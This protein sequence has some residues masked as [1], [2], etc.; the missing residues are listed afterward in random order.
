MS[1]FVLIHG[2][3]DVGWSWH[4]VAAELEA[5][6]HE[7]F[8]PDL[9]ADDDSLTLEDYTDAVVAAVGARQDTVVVG[10]SFGAFTAPLVAER[11][12][13]RLLVLAAGMI[14]LPGEPPERWWADSGYLAAAEEQAAR[15]GGLTGND[16]PYVSFYQDVPRWLVDEALRRERAHPS[17]AA[18]QTPWP[19]ERWPDM[20]TRFVVFADDRFFPPSFLRR[21]AL[22]RLG[23]IADE[24]PGGHCA[25]LSRPREIAELLVG[26]L[27]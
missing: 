15:D 11:L 4:L 6:G 13:S 17:R 23:V 24:V 2:G 7:V 21:L 26:Y 8:A 16:D 25:M 14:P 19:L 10:H 20:P 27:D 12:S 1:T 5:R 22:E 3:G 18:M 9:L